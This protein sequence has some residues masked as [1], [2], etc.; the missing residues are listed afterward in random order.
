LP[1][2]DIIK[3]LYY[4]RYVEKVFPRPLLSGAAGIIANFDPFR[5]PLE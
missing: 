2:F 1:I 3:I 4:N 5:P